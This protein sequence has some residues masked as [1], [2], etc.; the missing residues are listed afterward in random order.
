M[1]YYREVAEGKLLD[2]VAARDKMV[3]W[4]AES[5]TNGTSPSRGRVA[6]GLFLIGGVIG[7]LESN[8]LTD[9]PDDDIDFILGGL[10]LPNPV[11]TFSDRLDE[12]FDAQIGAV[13][14][15]VNLGADD[16]AELLFR[17]STLSMRF[18]QTAREIADA[19]LAAAGWM[20]EV[21]P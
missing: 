20:N 6:A 7:F 10:K 5:H 11:M 4:L 2:Y 16:I 3:E 1:S 15:D 9:T 19:N 13:G 18:D 21:R 14:R 12:V 8:P 17:N